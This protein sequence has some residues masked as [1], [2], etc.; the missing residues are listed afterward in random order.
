M[1]SGTQKVFSNTLSE[2]FKPHFWFLVKNRSTFLRLRNAYALP[3]PQKSAGGLRSTLLVLG[4]TETVFL[5]P[6]QAC[7][8]HTQPST[9]APP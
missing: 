8:C 9:K 4:K 2:G 6:S 1:P 3:N 7:G 5:M